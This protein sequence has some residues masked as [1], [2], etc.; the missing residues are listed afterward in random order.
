MHHRSVG[1]APTDLLRVA[2]I[3]PVRGEAKCDGGR[4]SMRLPQA[5]AAAAVAV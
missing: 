2:V 1:H 5:R 4:R 3:S